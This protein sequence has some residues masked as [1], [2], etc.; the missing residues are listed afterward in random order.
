MRRNVGGWEIAG[1]AVLLLAVLLA[2]SSSGTLVAKRSVMESP[3]V[4][5]TL[6]ECD[7]DILK[8]LVQNLT[9]EPMV[10]LRDE[11]T[12]RTAQTTLRRDPGGVSNVYN[13]PPYGAHDVNVRFDVSGMQSGAS[14]EVHFTGAILLSGRAIPVDPILVQ[15]Q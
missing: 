5:V 13:V 7:G 15:R 12:L 14:A 11:I 4:R 1:A 2:C 9:P 10:I 3:G 6:V 8:F